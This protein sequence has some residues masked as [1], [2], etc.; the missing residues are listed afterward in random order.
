VLKEIEGGVD[1]KEVRIMAIKE[2]DLFK[3]VSQRFIT[4]IANNS[5]EETFKKNSFIFKTG[6]KAS[7]FFVLAEGA[8]DIS[9]GKREG[10]HMSV[11]KP[12][13]IFG[14]SALVEPY[15]YTAN[16]K[17][18]KDTRVIRVSRDLIEQAISEHPAEGLAVL[19]NLTGII[20]QRLRYAYKSLVPEM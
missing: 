6:E 5:E 10:A 4:K 12:G 2:S 14:W 1:V 20:A 19:K 17:A 8:I 16:A 15:V 9:L 13:E 11:S 7:N 3:G 18:T